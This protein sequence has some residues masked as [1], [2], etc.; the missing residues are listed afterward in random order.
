MLGVRAPLRIAPTRVVD[1][2]AAHG[3]RRNGQEM[4]AVL[5]LHALVIDQPQV[6]FVDQRRRLQAVAGALALHVVVR[7][8]TEFVVHDR[9]QQSERRCPR[10]STPGEAQLTSSGTGSLAHPPRCIV[11]RVGLYMRP[12]PFLRLIAPSRLLR[13]FG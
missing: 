5:P 9:R 3:L 7:Q 11:T 8:T 13:L 10:R 6:G 2:D 4:G 12:S 1:E